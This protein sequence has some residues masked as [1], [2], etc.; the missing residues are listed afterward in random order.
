MKVVIEIEE[1]LNEVEIVIRCRQLSKDIQEIQRLIQNASSGVSSLVFYKN[2]MEFYFPPEDILF[3]ETSSECVY[4]HTAGDA[5]LTKTRLYELEEILPPDFI[6]V[7]KST[8]LNIRHI[9]AIER[10]LASASLIKFKKSHKQVYASRSY[11]NNLKQR[12][13]ERFLYR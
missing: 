8:I 3:F 9:L 10:N 1:N 11:F 4:A 7:S 13:A 12:I 5:F 2:N 6:R